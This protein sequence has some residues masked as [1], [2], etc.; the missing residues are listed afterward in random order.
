[1]IKGFTNDDYFLLLCSAFKRLQLNYYMSDNYL[2]VVN[3]STISLAAR[4][5]QNISLVA[6]EKNYTCET[7]DYLFTCL[8]VPSDWKYWDGGVYMPY[9]WVQESVV[10]DEDTA[11]GIK[12]INDTINF[13]YDVQLW[14]FVAA[15]KHQSSK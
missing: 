14:S 11:N 13:A 6:P 12:V 8:A 4:T 7:W 5:C 2:P 10:Y 15:G 9:A 3:E 1:M